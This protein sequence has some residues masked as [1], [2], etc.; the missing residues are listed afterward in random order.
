MNKLTLED[1]S[2]IH[3]KPVL[4]KRNGDSQWRICTGTSGN[5]VLFYDEPYHRIFSDYEF[6]VY[7]QEKEK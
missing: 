6:Y 1:L 2:H 7:D 5:E 3:G 4:L